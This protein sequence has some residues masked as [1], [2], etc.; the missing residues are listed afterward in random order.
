M[1]IMVVWS[2][3]CVLLAGNRISLI[4]RSQLIS[5]DIDE[6]GDVR[7]VQVRTEENRRVGIFT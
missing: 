2:V 3:C 7:K 6:Y 4:T 5:D 1:L